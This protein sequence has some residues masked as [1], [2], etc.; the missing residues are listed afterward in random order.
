MAP[1]VTLYVSGCS[2]LHHFEFVY[3]LFGVWVPD[4]GGIFYCRSDIGLVAV[5]F[6]WQLLVLRLR[7]ARVLFGFFVI[8]SIWWF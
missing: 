3:I 8:A 1:P 7:K 2:P 4:S 6:D 5:Y